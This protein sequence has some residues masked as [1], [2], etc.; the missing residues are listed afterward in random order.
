MGETFQK[1]STQKVQNLPT[2]FHPPIQLP[3]ESPGK[4][5][6]LEDDS[7]P[8]NL[9]FLFE[10]NTYSSPFVSRERKEPFHFQEGG[11]PP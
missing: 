10:K 6:G 8:I 3:S 9:T 5:V 11:Y 7:S 2:F 1:Q 4:I